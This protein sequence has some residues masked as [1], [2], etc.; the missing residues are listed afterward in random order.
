MTREPAWFAIRTR[1]AL[2][3]GCAIAVDMPLAGVTP[4]AING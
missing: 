4:S 2:A 1:Y 3:A